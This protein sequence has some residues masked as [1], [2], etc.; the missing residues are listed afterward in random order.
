MI[1][2]AIIK[3]VSKFRAGN[4]TEKTVRSTFSL[5][6]AKTSLEFFLRVPNNLLLNDF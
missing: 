3:L 6:S 5:V 1:D 4:K 2:I